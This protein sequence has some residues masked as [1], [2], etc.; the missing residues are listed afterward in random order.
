MNEVCKF[1]HMLENGDAADD[2]IP[3]IDYDVKIQSKGVVYKKNIFKPFEM[4]VDLTVP[5]SLGVS[6]FGNKLI[7]DICFED[8]DLI[9]SG[10][11]IINYCPMCGR[12]LKE[13][14]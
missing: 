8:G 10:E 12:K 2:H 14:K 5:V 3:L 1:C 9:A 13:D 4:K 6:I 11:N 7:N